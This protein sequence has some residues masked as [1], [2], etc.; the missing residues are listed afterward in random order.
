MKKISLFIFF[1]MILLSGC[2]R[3]IDVSSSNLPPITNTADVGEK[4]FYGNIELPEDLFS[5][6]AL[7]DNSL[8]YL[9]DNETGVGV[10][11][12]DVNT[13]KAVEVCKLEDHLISPANCAVLDGMLYFNY[14]T[15]DGLRKMIAIDIQHTTAKTVITEERI[16]GLVYSVASCGN[17]FSLKH[18]SEGVSVVECYVPQEETAI[19]LCHANDIRA[20]SSFEEQIYIIVSDKDGKY[21]LRGYNGKG[22]IVKTVFIPYANDILNESQ[23]SHFHIMEKSLHN[24]LYLENF[25]S[26]SALY[27]TDG[28]SLVTVEDWCIAT[29]SLSESPQYVFFLR[30][31]DKELIIYEEGTEELREYELDIPEGYIIRYVYSDLNNPQRVMV[32]LK[33]IETGDELV[34]IVDTDS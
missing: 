18:T 20:I 22:D 32:S 27:N 3:I 8:V 10:S 24:S 19:V 15:I 6:K 5:I 7:Y 33:N 28:I 25:S 31:S 1:T 17:I 23:V 21:F 11:V 29:D 9:T 26:Q 14:M 16:N 13:E 34:S 2:G 12:F 30:D 4:L